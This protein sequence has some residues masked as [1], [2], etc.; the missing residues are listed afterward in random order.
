M[1]IIN[2]KTNDK[3]LLN[4]PQ[5]I[6]LLKKFIKSY[7]YGSSLKSKTK[8]NNKSKT[9]TN[10]NLRTKTNSN[11]RTNTNTM[12][13]NSMNPQLQKFRSKRTKYIFR[14]NDVTFYFTHKPERNHIYIGSF[15][16][17]GRQDNTS[18]RGSGALFLKAIIR[19]YLS[20]TKFQNSKII[21]D[22]VPEWWVKQGFIIDDEEEDYDVLEGGLEALKTW[23]EN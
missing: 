7:Q 6:D 8:T 22:F 10:S 1:I 13:Y 20:K 12:E 16:R 19:N 18:E 14:H 17:E 23:A 21:G 2:P 11:L 4:T 9:K 5:G 15:Y 3:F